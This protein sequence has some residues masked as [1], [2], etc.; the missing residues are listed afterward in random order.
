MWFLFA[1][2]AALLNATYRLS[3]QYLKLSGH[4][5]TVLIKCGQILI[6][7]PFLFFIEWPENYIFYL[8]A[9]LTAPLVLIQDRSFLNFSVTYGAGAITRIE[10][11]SVPIV[12]ITWLIIQPTEF[13]SLLDKPLIFFGILICLF[14]SIGFSFRMRR[15]D[16]SF[17]ALK[18][19]I[20]L[21]IIAA[22]INIVAKIGI[23]NA[24]SINGIIAWVFI[25][26]LCLIAL[27]PFMKRKKDKNEEQQT[28]NK[29]KLI[30]SAIGL[31]ILLNIF[32]ILRLYGFILTSNPAY[33]TAVMLTAPFWIMLF[34]RFV[35]HKEEADIKSGIGI[36][37]SAITLSLLVSL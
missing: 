8:I 18:A 22:S 14:A 28:L 23:D 30:L 7:F 32:I 17:S 27:S 19:M 25:Q 10:P 6:F 12:F 4:T 34:Y 29:Q 35:G 1:I 2:S 13:L 24:P 3:N 15:C 11:L 33:V 37:I 9:F 21:I 16:V 26:S 31:S 5:L 20:P 36:V